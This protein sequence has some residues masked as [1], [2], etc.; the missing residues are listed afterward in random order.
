[1][2]VRKDQIE[3]A[4]RPKR[5]AGGAHLDHVESLEDR[6]APSVVGG[7]GLVD[8]SDGVPPPDPTAGDPQPGD[9]YSAPT[10]PPHADE[11]PPPPEAPPPDPD[12]PPN[13]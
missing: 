5:S 1:V 10:P 11:P 6:V 12:A 8:G 4:E 13:P 2:D 7:S 3:P 9:D